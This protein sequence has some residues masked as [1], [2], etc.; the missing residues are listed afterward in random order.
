MSLVF[1]GLVFLSVIFNAAYAL[2]LN[3]ELK[4]RII[5]VIPG[6][7]TIV[8]NRGIEDYI[9]HQEH[10]KIEVD[11]VF[12]ARAVAVRTSLR[13]AYLKLYRVAN[14]K[15][16]TANAD[17][18]ISSL[19]K[20][21]VPIYVEEEIR[22]RDFY[23]DLQKLE[24]D[25]DRKIIAQNQLM[26]SD[27]PPVM[28]AVH[29]DKHYRYI[30]RELKVYETDTYHSESIWEAFSAKNMFFNI[31]ASPYQTQRLNNQKNINYGLTIGTGRG[32]KYELSFN[33]TQNLFISQNQF[34]NFKNEFSSTNADL[35]LDINR[36]TPKVSYF[37]LGSY[38]QQKQSDPIFG[39]IYPVKNQSRIGPF[40]IKYHIHESSTISRFDISYI[41]LYETRVSEVLDYNLLQINIQDR[42]NFRH[43]VRVRFDMNIPQSRFYFRNTLFWRPAMYKSS[44]E[45]DFNDVDINNTFSIGYQLTNNASIDYM[46]IYTNDIRLQRD[47]GIEPIN[48]INQ[49]NFRLSF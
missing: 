7:N 37:L 36:V 2:D 6:K 3:D 28:D 15:L 40:G 1:S 25:I 46:N 10:M 9:K 44:F 22:E 39:E 23:F 32:R 21:E 38:L 12:A 41:P 49:F 29:P 20:S 16:L 31:F 19:Q 13:T 35:T 26:T 27:L 17:I 45:L 14:P 18:K 4:T 11:G 43:S 33:L 34:S 8:I 42:K 24:Q 47:N 5:K 30:D 48:M